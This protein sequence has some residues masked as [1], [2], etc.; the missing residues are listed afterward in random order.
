[1]VGTDRAVGKAPARERNDAVRDAD[2]TAVVLARVDVSDLPEAH[3][4]RF[5]R[6][7]T[8]SAVAAA[9]QRTVADWL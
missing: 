4:V 1:M 9:G 8:V 3:E 2:E 5:Q 7:G 6:L